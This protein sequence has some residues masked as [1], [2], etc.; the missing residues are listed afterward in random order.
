MLSQGVKITIAERFPAAIFCDVVVCK[1]SKRGFSQWNWTEL[2]IAPARHLPNWRNS[3]TAEMHRSLRSTCLNIGKFLQ[4]LQM[5][6]SLEQVCSICWWHNLDCKEHLKFG[7]WACA[8]IT[9]RGLSFTNGT[10]NEQYDWTIVSAN[11]GIIRLFRAGKQALLTE[12]FTIAFTANMKRHKT[13]CP[14]F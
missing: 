6:P 8:C 4:A 14:L 7:A 2:Q 3:N 9:L 1:K 5:M 10:R 11:I 13:R 12:T